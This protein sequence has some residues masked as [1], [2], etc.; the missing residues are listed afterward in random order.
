MGNWKAVRR[1]MNKGNQ[2]IE[3]FDL[4]IDPGETRDLAAEQP[5]LIAK[6]RERFVSARTESIEFPL[7]PRASGQ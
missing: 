2:A 1:N 7:G 3:L 5:E 4:S 6:A